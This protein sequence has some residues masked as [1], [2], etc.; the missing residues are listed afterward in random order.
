MRKWR[1]TRSWPLSCLKREVQ[2]QIPL[3]QS[4]HVLASAQ[5]ATS[6]LCSTGSRREKRHTCHDSCSL[7]HKARA[8]ALPARLPEP[9]RT[10]VLPP[11]K[12]TG[13]VPKQTHWE[14]CPGRVQCASDSVE[15]W[16][17]WDFPLFLHC[18]ITSTQKST[19]HKEWLH[20]H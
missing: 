15:Q 10:V 17:D 1:T 19:W 6:G 4:G 11:S 16:Q 12:Y 2:Q 8:L 7:G 9:A 5:L 3:A 14:L 13:M 20:K 18:S